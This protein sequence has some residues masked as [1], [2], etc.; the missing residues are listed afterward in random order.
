MTCRTAEE[1]IQK[2]LDGLLTPEE[3]ARMDAHLASCAACRRDWDAHR[4]LARVAGRWVRPGPQD[5][6]GD[7]FTAAVLSRIA[8]RPVFASSSR[9]LWLPLAATVFLIVLLT[10]LPGLLL[11]GL[12]TVGIAARQTPGWLLS[13]LRGLPSDASTIWGALTAGVPVRSWV[14]PALLAVVAANG[15]FCARARQAHTLRDLS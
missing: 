3:R 14:W 4:A 7:A 10:W 5:D 8:A 9:P 13:N 2:S 15:M 1:E 6:P 11:P 12:D